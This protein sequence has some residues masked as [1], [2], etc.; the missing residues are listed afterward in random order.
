MV[1][2]PYQH[3]QM[4]VG[5]PDAGDGRIT[6]VSK[7]NGGAEGRTCGLCARTV[8]RLT[9]HHLIPKTRHK[10]KRNK[11]TFDRRE[12]H[13]TVGLCCP[14]HRH[15]HTILDNKELER[16][17][18]TLEALRAHPDLGRFA[19]WISKKPH[20]TVADAERTRA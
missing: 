2:Y 12:I 20:G 17:Y 9:R 5:S 15:V 14:C 19:D 3:A 11:K 10:N 4:V 6:R 16:E 18:N 8:Q 13:H 7:A 1:G